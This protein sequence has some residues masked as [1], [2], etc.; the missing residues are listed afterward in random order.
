[1][2]ETS[3]WAELIDLLDIGLIHSGPYDWVAGSRPNCCTVH[4]V[5]M[6]QN[7]AGSKLC[8]CSIYKHITLHPSPRSHGLQLLPS[9]KYQRIQSLM[10]WVDSLSV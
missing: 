4:R 7:L 10:L 3:V 5:E 9:L 8:Q 6:V 2:A 1:M